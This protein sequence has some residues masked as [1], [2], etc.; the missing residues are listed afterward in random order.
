[1]HIFRRED[2]TSNRKELLTVPANKAQTL[3]TNM[4]LNTAEPTTAPRPMSSW[5][6]IQTNTIHLATWCSRRMY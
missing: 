6:H 1:V 4:M 2:N 3:I 5:Q